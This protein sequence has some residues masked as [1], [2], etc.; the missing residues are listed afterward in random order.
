MCRTPKTKL[1]WRN[2]WLTEAQKHLDQAGTD[3]TIETA[4]ANKGYHK[5]ETLADCVE[6]GI[7]TYIP[8]PDT[9][10]QRRWTDKPPE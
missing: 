8:E 7:K 9:K 5:N 1:E 4:A 10:H 6:C 2:R 3:I